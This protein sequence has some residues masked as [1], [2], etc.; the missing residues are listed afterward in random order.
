MGCF[1]QLEY[2][3]RDKADRL[4]KT[5]KIAFLKTCALLVE[6]KQGLQECSLA[7]GRCVH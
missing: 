6:L 2:K 7:A 1:L 5:Q 4:P 3:G